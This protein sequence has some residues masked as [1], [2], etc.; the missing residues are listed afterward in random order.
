MKAKLNSNE[1]IEYCFQQQYRSLFKHKLSFESL[2]A[3]KCFTLH[4]RLFWNFFRCYF[5]PFPAEY[6]NLE[7]HVL[8]NDY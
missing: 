5:Q 1:L 7:L 4:L 6:N 8:L 3:K 2:V